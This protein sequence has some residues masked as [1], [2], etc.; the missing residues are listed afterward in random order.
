M[1]KPLTAITVFLPTDE[2]HSV[3]VMDGG[4]PSPSALQ[5]WVRAPPA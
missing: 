5:G 1:I 3:R 4:R 2:F